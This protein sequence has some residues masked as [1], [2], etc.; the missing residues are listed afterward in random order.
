[1]AVE[2]LPHDSSWAHY[3]HH[4]DTHVKRMYD[5]DEPALTLK[6]RTEANDHDDQMM[7]EMELL[8]HSDEWSQLNLQALVPVTRLTTPP[9]LSGPFCR[10]KMCF[11]RVKACNHI[12]AEDSALDEEDLVHDEL[13]HPFD[14]FWLAGQ[15]KI[16]KRHNVEL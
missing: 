10:R 16:L 4:A 14:E 11:E 8:M 5:W 9:S 7:V 13:S 6:K 12:R 2:K 3:A 1:M 15:K